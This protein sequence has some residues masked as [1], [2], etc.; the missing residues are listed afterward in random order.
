MDEYQSPSPQ[1]VTCEGCGTS[2]QATEGWLFRPT[3][4]GPVALCPSCAVKTQQEFEQQTRDVNMPQA[5]L[6]G[7]LAALIGAGVWYGLVIASNFKLG[8]VAVGLGWLVGVAVVRGAGNKRSFHLQIL[9]GLL[10][11]FGLGVGEYLTINHF[12][13]EAFEDFS[14]WLTLEQFI[15]IYPLIL[16]EGNWVLDIVFYLI[17]LYEGYIQPRPLKLEA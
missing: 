3:K 7:A 12:A 14:G 9:G 8:I 13:R 11:L 5:V 1:T 16:A 15:Q 6:Y 17:A 10:A 4:E 2:G